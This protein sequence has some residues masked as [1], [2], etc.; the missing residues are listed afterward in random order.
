ME[1]PCQYTLKGSTN[2]VRKIRIFLASCESNYKLVKF[3]DEV[4][5]SND[6]VIKTE[7]NDGKATA[8]SEPQ[9]NDLVMSIATTF[10]GLEEGIF[11]W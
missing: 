3:D 5:M 8:K 2:E 7:P 4:S 11:N 9:V 6:N 1:I 10:A